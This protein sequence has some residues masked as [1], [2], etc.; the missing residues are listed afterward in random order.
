[1]SRPELPR[2]AMG[3]PLANGAYDLYRVVVRNATAK[4]ATH[5]NSKIPISSQVE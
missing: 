4:L 5:Q 3:V 2:Q 1:M